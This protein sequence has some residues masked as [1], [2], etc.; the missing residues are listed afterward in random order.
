MKIKVFVPFFNEHMLARINILS[1]LN[2][3]DEFHLTE[4]NFTFQGKKRNL[5]LI[6]VLFPRHHQFLITIP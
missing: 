4:A 3:V 2:W 6:K 5:F 1:S